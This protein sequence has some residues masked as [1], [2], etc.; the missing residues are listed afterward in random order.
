MPKYDKRN[1]AVT[2]PGQVQTKEQLQF[3]VVSFP[4]D[5]HQIPTENTDTQFE[6]RNFSFEQGNCQ[7]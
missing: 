1:T 6:I 7:R 4:Q 5:H 2:F 3:L